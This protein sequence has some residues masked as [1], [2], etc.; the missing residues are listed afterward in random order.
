MRIDK[1]FLREGSLMAFFCVCLRECEC[2]LGKG[3][4]WAFEANFAINN[5]K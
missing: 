4:W 3:M 1:L 5:M 2:G